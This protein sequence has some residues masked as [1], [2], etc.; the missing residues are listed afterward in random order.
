VRA[1]AG[2]PR[3]VCLLARAAWLE[4]AR[5]ETREINAPTMQLAM[6]QVPGLIGLT[7]H[8]S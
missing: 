7:R 5:A 6:D 3:S 2:V 8:N 4:A 1:T